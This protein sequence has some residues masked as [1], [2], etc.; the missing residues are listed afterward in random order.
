MKKILMLLAGVLTAFPALAQQT[1]SPT[2][3][4]PQNVRNQRFVSVMPTYQT[5]NF[6]ANPDETHKLSQ[7]SNQ[8]LVYYQ[9]N[10][11]VLLS[12][13]NTQGTFNATCEGCTYTTPE[14]SLSGLGDTQVSVSYRLPNPNLIFNAT[15]NLPTGRSSVS[16]SE[17]ETLGLF[18]NQVLAFKLP[19]LGQGTAIMT[20][21]SGAFPLNDQVVLGGGL[22]YIV[23]GGFK[24]LA[25]YDYTYKPGNEVTADLGLNLRVGSNGSLGVDAM[26]TSYQE[27]V[28]VDQSVFKAGNKIST[29]LQYRQ[30]NP[31]S[32]WSAMLR[33]RSRAK[34]AVAQ[35]IGDKP[36]EES[37]NTNPAVMIARGTYRMN[38]DKQFVPGFT[39][40]LRSYEATPA[41]LS[42]ALVFG[43]GFE[44]DFRVSKSVLVPLRI[45]YVMGNVVNEKYY[46]TFG[47]LSELSASVGL[48]W[49]F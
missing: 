9:V 5:W 16:A 37:V 46:P 35:F 6:E 12:L 32:E 26:L 33:Y 31:T 4:D 36:V 43:I 2:T 10:N 3:E 18:S 48:Y 17:L 14:S 40:E 25:E 30:L 24:P 23:N 20:G 27:D 8:V 39:A 38:L 19:T 34:N 45:R 44:P 41:W 28:F 1:T 29:V 22:S 42:G 21:I 13:R 11:Q 15:L 49:S 7:V 47:S